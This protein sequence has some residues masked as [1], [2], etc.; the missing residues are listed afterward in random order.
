MQR[1]AEAAKVLAALAV[2]AAVF[3]CCVFAVSGYI[4]LFAQ[5]IN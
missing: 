1:A 4:W 5:I 3:F 2:S